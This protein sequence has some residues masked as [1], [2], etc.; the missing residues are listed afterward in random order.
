VCA[1]TKS[2]LGASP[3][4]RTRNALKVF[5]VCDVRRPSG[6]RSGTTASRNGASHAPG[7]EQSASARTLS[8]ST[9]RTLGA[10]AVPATSDAVSGGSGAGVRSET[11]FLIHPCPESR[12][13]AAWITPW[14]KHVSGVAACKNRLSSWSNQRHPSAPMNVTTRRIGT[15][16]ASPAL[17]RRTSSTNA[18]VT[19]TPSASMPPSSDAVP[20]ATNQPATVP[21]SAIPSRSVSLPM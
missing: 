7:S 1:D 6:T 15:G 14:A 2:T 12:T 20:H 3:V 21:R 4:V 16:P 17:S 8:V 18:S 9:T 5:G 19:T 13:R 10:R 11:P